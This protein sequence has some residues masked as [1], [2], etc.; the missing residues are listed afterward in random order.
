MPTLKDQEHQRCDDAVDTKKERL[1]M[2]D[3]DLDQFIHTFFAFTQEGY[4]SCLRLGRPCAQ[5]RKQTRV[6]PLPEPCPQDWRLSSDLCGSV[7]SLLQN[8]FPAVSSC[9]EG[10][11]VCAKASSG[12]FSLRFISLSAKEKWISGEVGTSRGGKSLP[13]CSP[14]MP[15][16][17]SAGLWGSAD[18]QT[19]DKGDP[20]PGV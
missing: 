20:L 7:T 4:H 2:S 19:W 5:R 18:A 16:L 15:P 1:C 13:C 3:P 14:R 10:H 9:W 6:V 17:A 11:P 12:H 8:P